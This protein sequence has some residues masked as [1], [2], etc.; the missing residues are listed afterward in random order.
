MRGIK[1][2]KLLTAMVITGPAIGVITN[3][4]KLV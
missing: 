2:T 3:G 4:F 1:I